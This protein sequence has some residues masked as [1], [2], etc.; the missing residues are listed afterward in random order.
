MRRLLLALLVGALVVISA[1]GGGSDGLGS[2]VGPGPTLAPNPVTGSV[3][4]IIAPPSAMSGGGGRSFRDFG[5]KERFR[6]PV[7]S[8]VGYLK[9]EIVVTSPDP[10][11]IYRIC[12]GINYPDR[13]IDYGCVSSTSP[14][15]KVMPFDGGAADVQFMNGG[16][17]ITAGFGRVYWQSEP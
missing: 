14:I 10:T 11:K 5:A 15:S 16:D 1:C 6:E 8:T 17:E 2:V 7:L 13:V 9:P 3:A 4:M 12:F